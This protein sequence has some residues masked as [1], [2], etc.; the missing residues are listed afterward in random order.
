MKARHLGLLAGATILGV[1]GARAQFD[2][3]RIKQGLDKAKDSAKKVSDTAGEATKMAKGVAGIGPEEE[4][5]IG[6]S[7]ASEVVGANGGIVRDEAIVRRINLVGKSLAR[8]S[9]RPELEWRFGV[10][11]S[12][13]VN[14]FS[15]P[16]GY[17]FITRGLYDLA[18]GDD[19]LAAVL[20]HE[21]AHV[22]RRHALAIVARTE[23]ISGA[24]TLAQKHSEQVRQIDTQLRQFDVG[25]DQIV[26]TL[27]EKGFDPATEYEADRDGRALAV[28]TGY[29]PGGLRGVLTQLQQRKDD[30]K[31]IFSTHP[32]LADRIKRLPNDPA[33]PPPATPEK[34]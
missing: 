20:A 10:L 28:L 30:S 29:A 21:I 8:Y 1:I 15:A 3:S 17:V 22:T 6:G 13:N 19:A 2:L 18:V 7:V 34:P 9:T 23:F 33:P 4:R 24:S 12:D 11:A 26:K 27:F 5:V 16:G 14:A 25:V 32:P 31:K